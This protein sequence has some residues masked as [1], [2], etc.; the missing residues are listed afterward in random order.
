[1]ESTTSLYPWGQTQ[2]FESGIDLNPESIVSVNAEALQKDQWKIKKEQEEM[3]EIKS[4]HDIY[5][6]DLKN[7]WS[8]YD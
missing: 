7:V 2:T 6:F 8:S 3:F 1:M 4:I 5:K